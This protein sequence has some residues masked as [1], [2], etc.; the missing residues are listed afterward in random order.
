M[1]I[2]IYTFQDHI[3]KYPILLILAVTTTCHISFIHERVDKT[4]VAD[5]PQIS[6][7]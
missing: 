1:F 5:N 2:I 3:V 7:S 6:A 4:V